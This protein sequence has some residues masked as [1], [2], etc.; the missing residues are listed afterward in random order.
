LSVGG[1]VA[2]KFKTHPWL[3]AILCESFVDALLKLCWSVV[4]ARRCCV[5]PFGDP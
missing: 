5:Q 4:G 1:A 3:R 2:V